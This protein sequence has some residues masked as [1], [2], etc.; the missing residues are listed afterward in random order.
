MTR[1]D[2]QFEPFSFGSGHPP[3]SLGRVRRRYW[4]I[5]LILLGLAA[6]GG[7]LVQY[8]RPRL[9]RWLAATPFGDRFVGTPLL[10]SRETGTLQ[11]YKWRDESGAWNITDRPPPPGTEYESLDYPP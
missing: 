11:V 10:P 1:R 9:E 5:P 4:L 8:E 2:D 7:Y 3:T 6:A